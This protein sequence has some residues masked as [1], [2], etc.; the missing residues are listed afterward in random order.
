MY[1]LVH[2]V[3]VVRHDSATSSHRGR[4]CASGQFEVSATF[5]LLVQADSTLFSP[6]ENRELAHVSY[7][8]RGCVV[9]MTPR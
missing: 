5:P 1:V 9:D 6:E 2:Y 7:V 4:P 8:V 3:L